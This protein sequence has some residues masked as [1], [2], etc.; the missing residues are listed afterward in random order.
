MAGAE[1]FTKLLVS[2]GITNTKTVGLEES[3][4]AVVLNTLTLF[5][6][7][8]TGD[9][10]LAGT[11]SGISALDAFA[12]VRGT[13]PFAVGVWRGLAFTFR[14]VERARLFRALGVGISAVS[15]NIPHADGII[16]ANG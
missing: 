1:E 4:R 16:L 6:V 8:E 10:A 11:R 12:S 14:S 2:D 5:V 15:I 7:P 9:V 3:P 13:V